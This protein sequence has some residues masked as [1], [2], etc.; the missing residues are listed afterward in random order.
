MGD[1][2]LL[3]QDGGMV[4]DMIPYEGGK[5]YGP[6]TRKQDDRSHIVILFPNG[7]RLTVSYPKYLMECKLERYL[8]DSEEVHHKDEDV[9][10]NEIGNLKVMNGTEHRRMHMTK[11][12]PETWICAYCGLPFIA[13]PKQIHT[14]RT[15]L[16]RGK[17]KT[18]P[19]CSK[20][21][22][23]KVNH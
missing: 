14:R 3:S 13:E 15:N 17:V 8:E 12:F 9:T 23:G 20:R 18:G 1:T 4:D 11:V 22:N 5:V 7:V 19:F 10:N 6:Y 16:K 2:K 21:C